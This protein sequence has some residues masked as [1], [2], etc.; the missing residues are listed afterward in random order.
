MT[1]RFI[2]RYKMGDTPWE[3]DGPDFNLVE[4]VSG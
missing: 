1:E 4:M 2:D 3:L